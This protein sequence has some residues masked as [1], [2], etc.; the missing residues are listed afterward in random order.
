MFSDFELLQHQLPLAIKIGGV[1]YEL[2]LI[3]D[4]AFL[5]E[6]K[7]E[8]NDGEFNVN[9]GIIKVA[10]KLRDSENLIDSSRTMTVLLHEILHGIVYHYIGDN[11]D[12]EEHIVTQMSKGLYQVVKENPELFKTIIELE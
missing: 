7:D 12:D 9:K 5:N 3:N 10:T 1:T 4:Y 11:L 8:S 6:N 2:N